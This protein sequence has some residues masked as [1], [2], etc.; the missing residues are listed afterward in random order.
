MP[1]VP[2]QVGLSTVR[3]RPVVALVKATAWTA[4]TMAAVGLTYWLAWLFLSSPTVTV[5]TSLAGSSAQCHSL[6]EVVAGHDQG[7][8]FDAGYIT[9]GA[10]STAQAIDSAC[11]EKRIGKLALVGL[12][13]APTLLIDVALLVAVRRRRD[14]RFMKFAH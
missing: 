2:E 11:D 7:D 1:S 14:E 3:A 6:A 5:Y 8:A 10:A 9:I 13:A 4:A 12:I